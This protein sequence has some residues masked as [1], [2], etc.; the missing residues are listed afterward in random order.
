MWWLKISNTIIKTREKIN[1]F[2]TYLT[3]RSV[4]ISLLCIELLK[5]AL[6]QLSNNN[7]NNELWIWNAFKWVLKVSVVDKSCKNFAKITTFFSYSLRYNK[8]EQL[9]I[10]EKLQYFWPK[11]S[12]STLKISLKQEV[13]TIR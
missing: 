10:R 8:C 13:K 3:I 7:R 2:Y 12:S 4:V 11:T 5:K 9:K 6:T 1:L